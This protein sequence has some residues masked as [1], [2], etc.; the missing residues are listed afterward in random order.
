MTKTVAICQ[1]RMGSTRLPGK[2]LLPL[3]DYTGQIGT[4]LGFVTWAADRTQVDQVIVAT[5]TLPQDDKIAEW[6]AV[7]G[8]D[9][10]RGSE[11]DVLTRC[12]GAAQQYDADIIVRLTGDCPLL[13][14]RVIDEVIQ[15]R[16]MKDVMYATNT[17]PPTY[18]DGLDVEVF[19][20]EALEIANREA[21]RL[22][23][24]DTV[25]RYM[26]RN[27]H[28]I[29]AA[30]LTCPLPDLVAERWVLDSPEDYKFIKE[31][32]NRISD[33]DPPSYLEI[34]KV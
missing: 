24:R 13:D 2:V 10:F 31:I 12:H 5:S 32:I 22:S 23:D 1:A 16:K 19:T 18:P 34:L 29:S 20:R 33:E 27:R 14:P 15:L 7:N 25:T 28:R 8:L 9:C 6:C 26:V 11:T 17:D 30:N 21:T 4:A 3:Y